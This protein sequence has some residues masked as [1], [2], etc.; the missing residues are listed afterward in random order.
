MSS[1]ADEAPIKQLAGIDSVYSTDILLEHL[2]GD[3]RSNTLRT[4]FTL[5]S[6][7]EDA[8]MSCDICVRSRADA[9]G[10]PSDGGAWRRVFDSIDTF[11]V[12]A[13]RGS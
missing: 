4:T 3:A 10:D 1:E 9:T 2:A 7:V 13:V 11:T 6:P 8:A 5:S 12:S